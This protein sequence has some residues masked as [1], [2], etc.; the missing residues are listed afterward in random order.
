[1]IHS[2]SGSCWNFI[3]WWCNNKVLLREL[4]QAPQSD[5]GIRMQN[6]R[7]QTN[8]FPSSSAQNT[9]LLCDQHIPLLFSPKH[10]P[11]LWP[12]QLW[13]D[14]VLFIPSWTV[15]WGLASQEETSVELPVPFT[16]CNLEWEPLGPTFSRRETC[17][18]LSGQ[19]WRL[20]PAHLQIGK[21]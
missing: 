2:H 13:A 9:C 12:T 19:P 6:T 8:T 7:V 15:A 10:L 17:Y 21:S 11:P 16:S 3:S 1:V 4:W 18:P 20:C 14:K 5:G